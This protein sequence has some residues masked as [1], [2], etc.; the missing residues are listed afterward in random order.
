MFISNKQ[1]NIFIYKINVEIKKGT[2]IIYINTLLVRL[3]LINVNDKTDRAKILWNLIWPYVRFLDAQ[4][5]RK[6]SPKILDFRKNLENP[7]NKIVNQPKKLLLFYRG[8]NDNA[9]RLK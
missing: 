1:F 2:S 7:Q 6:L 8:E 4:N 9:E 5:Y 3:Y